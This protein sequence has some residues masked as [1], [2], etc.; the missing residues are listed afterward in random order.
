MSH[1][2]T[3]V[4]FCQASMLSVTWH[5]FAPWLSNR[6]RSEIIVWSV[7]LLAT[8][9]VKINNLA[10]G[11]ERA[12]SASL[13]RALLRSRHFLWAEGVSPNAQYGCCSLTNWRDNASSGK[14]V[15]FDILQFWA[16]SAQLEKTIRNLSFCSENFRSE[17][18][19]RVLR[20]S[21]TCS[22]LIRLSRCSR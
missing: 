19:E 8:V 16:K 13:A 9:L 12:R 18:L 2:N 22:V 3:V 10:A 5:L 1:F 7:V 21:R 11:R 14:T 20:R 15:E 4:I 6:K 17:L